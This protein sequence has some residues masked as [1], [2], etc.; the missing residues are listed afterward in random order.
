MKMAGEW[1]FHTL[2]TPLEEFVG[3]ETSPY[4][5]DEVSGRLFSLHFNTSR[6]GERLYGGRGRGA[7]EE[8][9]KKMG[10]DS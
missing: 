3:K 6:L 2:P 1:L 10:K 9:Q 7:V 8:G 5:G 4:Q